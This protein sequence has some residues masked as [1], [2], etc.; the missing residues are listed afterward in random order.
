[1]ASSYFSSRFVSQSKIVV[2]KLVVRIDL[3]LL[4]EGR[5]RLIVLVESK[6]GAAEIVPCR[7]VLGLLLH[8]ALEQLDR[9]LE[10]VVL[11]RLDARL[12]QVV[13]GLVAADSRGTGRLVLQHNVLRLIGGHRPLK[14]SIVLQSLERQLANQQLQV[15]NAR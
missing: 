7:F 6:I 3:N 11:E 12:V 2:G 5:D 1:M 9:Q 4:L 13:G 15:A 14:R 8:H 10:I